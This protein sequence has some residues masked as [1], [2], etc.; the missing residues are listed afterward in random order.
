MILGPLHNSKLFS[1]D[2]RNFSNQIAQKLFE[3]S[4]L[5]NLSQREVK[6]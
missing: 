6:S 2:Q 5:I 1:A 4:F 3:E